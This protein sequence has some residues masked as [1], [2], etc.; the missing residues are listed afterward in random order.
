MIKEKKTPPTRASQPTM[1]TSGSTRPN[2][3]PKKV[4][5]PNDDG[6]GN[7]DEGGSSHGHG[8]G[9]HGSGGL[10]RNPPGERI[11]QGRGGGSNDSGGSNGN[12]E[13]PDRGRGP[14]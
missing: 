7:P 10:N 4:G 6:D 8:R 14:P 11:A 2:V 9:S 5:A 1:A 12:G 3:P 13:P